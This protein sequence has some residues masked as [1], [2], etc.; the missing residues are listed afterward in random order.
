MFK[1]ARYAFP[2]A[3]GLSALAAGIFTLTF[4]A[5]AIGQQS[6]F[7]EPDLGDLANVTLGG[8]FIDFELQVAAPSATLRVSGPEG[9]VLSRQLDGAPPFVTA[10]L[11]LDASPSRMHD[12]DP[13][14]PSAAPNWK[15]LPEGIYHYELMLYGEG[16][17]VEFVRGSFK[18]EGGSI[19]HRGQHSAAPQIDSDEVSSISEPGPFSRAVGAVLN[20]LV[21]SAHAQAV[22]SDQFVTVL[23]ANSSNNTRINFIQNDFEN[24]GVQA[25]DGSLNIARGT[26]PDFTDILMTFSVLGKVGLNT[27]APQELFHI[28]G[29][30]TRSA[31][32]ID[33]TQTGYNIATGSTTGFT[34]AQHMGAS[35]TPFRMDPG[36]PTNAFR[37]VANGNIGMGTATPSAALHIRRTNGTATILLQE[38]Q[39]ID[40]NQQFTMRS[41][42]NTGFLFENTRDDSTWQ[43]RTGGPSGNSDSF[44]INR[45][46]T[47]APEFILQ[48]NGNASFRGNVTANGI[49][50]TSS[51]ETKTSIAPL[52]PHEVLAKLD[53]LEVSQWRYTSEDEGAVHFGPMA[54]DFH[55]IFGLSDGRTLNMID[56]NGVAF[57]AI[58]ALSENNRELRERLAELES[59]IAGQQFS[60]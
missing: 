42:G 14:V 45:A 55:K 29:T 12:Y 17:A 33:N 24:V 35:A 2:T 50:L 10:D 43:F 57:A 23:D 38:T 32:R 25:R 13:N 46:G 9:Y 60:L 7:P 49:L 5:I 53:T 52:D 8:G 37:M 58:Q 20:F 59:Q 30:G 11:L 47:G 34:I 40:I 3:L 19:L 28:N 56:T 18:V 15:Q 26:G 22:F 51:R 36:A 27:T 31:V 54:E 1:V 48:S 44:L 21:P 39:A 41:N 4:S 16:R 6:E